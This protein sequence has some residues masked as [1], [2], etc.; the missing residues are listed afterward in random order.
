MLF[1]ATP[2][3]RAHRKRFYRCTWYSKINFKK[4]C[5]VS[6]LHI[7]F[8]VHTTVS[9]W[10]PRSTQTHFRPNAAGKKP[11]KTK[12][13]KNGNARRARTLPVGA[14]FSVLPTDK[15]FP[16]YCANANLYFSYC[17]QLMDTSETKCKQY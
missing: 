14:I 3:L 17:I 6:E 13:I 8:I 15:I 9:L 7:N 5:Q 2:C 16:A 1:S 12:K 11:F 10:T 4:R